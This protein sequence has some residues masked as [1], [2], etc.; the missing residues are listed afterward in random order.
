MGQRGLTLLETIIAIGILGSLMVCLAALFTSF[1]RTSDKTGDLTVG[2]QLA[3][4]VLQEAV[5]ARR[6][7]P[8]PASLIRLYTHDASQPT[9]FTYQIDSTPKVLPGGTVANSYYLDAH[10]WWSPPGIPSN[11]GKGRQEA[12]CRRL[13]SL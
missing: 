3:D 6:F 10:G 1:L 7:D 9:E 12:H 2:L 4:K 11:L 13:V 5:T 8:T